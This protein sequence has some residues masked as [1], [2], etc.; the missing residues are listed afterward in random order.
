MTGLLVS[1]IVTLITPLP[2]VLPVAVAFVSAKVWPYEA[3]CKRETDD[4]RKNCNLDFQGYFLSRTSA[5]HVS[6]ETTETYFPLPNTRS[7]L[8]TFSEWFVLLADGVRVKKRA[9]ARMVLRLLS[10]SQVSTRVLDTASDSSPCARRSVTAKSI[11]PGCLRAK[12]NAS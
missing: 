9:R 2:I 8:L 7:P 12:S 11:D 10:E 5:A 4:D 6:R 1:V 3:G